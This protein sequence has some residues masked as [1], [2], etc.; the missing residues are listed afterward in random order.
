MTFA[1][2][3]VV[4]HYWNLDI[5]EVNT[6]FCNKGSAI[7]RGVTDIIALGAFLTVQHF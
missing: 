2:V 1:F 7:E 4:Y 5:I 3:E 6:I